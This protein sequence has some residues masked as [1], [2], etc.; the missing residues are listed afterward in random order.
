MGV[1]MVRAASKLRP[2]WRT[3]ERSYP[4]GSPRGYLGLW[5]RRL[6]LA[7]TSKLRRATS[8]RLASLRTYRN[9]T[10]GVLN[11]PGLIRRGHAVQTRASLEGFFRSGII[12]ITGVQ[13]RVDNYINA[14]WA[15]DWNADEYGWPTKNKAREW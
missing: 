9:V 3:A 8:D 15:F 13:Q 12:R 4:L 2:P 7:R 11:S 1:Y 6:P 5:R 14:M 10:R